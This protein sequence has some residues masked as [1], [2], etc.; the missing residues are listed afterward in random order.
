MNDTTIGGK[1]P[2]YGYLGGLVLDKMNIQKDLQ[3]SNKGGQRK[4]VSFTDLGEETNAMNTMSKSKSPLQLAD[5]V[6]QFLFHG[7]TGFWMPIA[8]FLTNQANSADLYL[9]V[10]DSKGLLDDLD[11]QSNLHKIRWVLQ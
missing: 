9:S 3:V 1:L 11:F 8:C 2:A 10:W 7:L 5:H 6:L 4:L